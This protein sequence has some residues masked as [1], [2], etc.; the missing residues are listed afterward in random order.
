MKLI[1]Y[2]IVLFL[3]T[4]FCLALDPDNIANGHVYLFEDGSAKDYTK[5]N[6][7]GNVTGNLKEEA[8]VIGTAVRFDGS[9]FVHIPDSNNINT[10][11]PFPNR[12]VLVVFNADNARTP[13][14][15]CIYEEGGRTRGLTIYVFEGQVW[16]GGW[17][18]AEYNWNGEWISAPIN[19]GQWYE[20]AL[21][22]RDASGKVEKDK[23]EMWL[24]GQLIERRDGGQL[25]AHGDDVAI[26]AVKQNT[27]FHDESGSGDGWFFEGL[28]D[29]VWIF[30]S[31]IDPADLRNPG[32][33][34][35]PADK[36]SI[37]WGDIKAR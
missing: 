31:S 26:G 36:L 12:T 35:N 27:V 1:L 20:V 28:V 33:A 18:R 15:Q 29:E 4:G 21:V 8:G 23:F 16:I 5:Q 25:H 37:S 32:F 9:T 2:L 34:V 13:D 3:L 19:S 14:I 24:N 30:N 7:N 10:G 11:G 17:N 6:H 22:I